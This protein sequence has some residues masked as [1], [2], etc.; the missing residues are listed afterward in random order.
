MVQPHQ[1]AIE[2]NI[3]RIKKPYTASS[4]HRTAQNSNVQR[5]R[6]F[7][8]EMET[9]SAKERPLHNARLVHVE[10][11]KA[12]EQDAPPRALVR[13][14]LDEELIVVHLDPKSSDSTSCI[15]E[16]GKLTKLHPE[17]R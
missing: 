16:K 13:H 7:G 15:F 6:L 12:R 2:L 9:V 11:P 4:K 8:T 10:T 3:Q 14:S 5:N 1:L 17:A